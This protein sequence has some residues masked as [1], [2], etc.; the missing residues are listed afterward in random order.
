MLE[1]FHLR[2]LVVFLVRRCVALFV[3]TR[4]FY[5]GMPPPPFGMPGGPP[6]PGGCGMPFPPFPANG[7]PPPNLPAIACLVLHQAASLRISRSRLQV[8]LVVSRLQDNLVD[9]LRAQELNKDRAHRL[10][11]VNLR[12]Q[13]EIEDKTFDMFRMFDLERS[14]GRRHQRKKNPLACIFSRIQSFARSARTLRKLWCSRSTV[15][16]RNW[17]ER[18]GKHRHPK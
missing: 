9:L 8:R 6:P 1:G 5:T 13:Q 16:T 15:I 2:F 3:L 18:F 12:V 7:V 4:L 11:L 14:T 17:D 10:D